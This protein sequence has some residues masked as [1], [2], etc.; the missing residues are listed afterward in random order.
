M[1]GA[2]RGAIITTKRITYKYT[3]TFSFLIFLNVYMIIIFFLTLFES[4]HD[5]N[6]VKKRNNIH[7]ETFSG[8]GH[9]YKH[10]NEYSPIA[11]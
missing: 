7:V 8:F 3:H 4:N 1:A 10:P 11:R 5:S 2:A 6:N 9:P